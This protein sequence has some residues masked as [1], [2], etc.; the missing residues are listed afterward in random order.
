MLRLTLLTA[1]GAI[2]LAAQTPVGGPS[3]GFIFD[4]KGHAIRQIRGIPGA[5]VL[6]DPLAAASA[7]ALSMK[8][9][10]AIINDDGWKTLDLATG[11]TSALPD[12]LSAS[13]RVSASESGTAAAFYD[14]DAATLTVVTGVG[15]AEL[16]AHAVALPGAITALATAD[17]GALLLAV[18]VD[19]SSEALYWVGADGSARQLA[20]LQSTASLLLTSRGATA[21]VS[22]R[23]ANKIWKIQDPG[24]NAAV[25]LVASDAD[26]VSTPVG[27]ALS[28]DGKRLWIANSGAHNLLAVDLATRTASAL[29]SPSDLSTL[30]P[31]PDGQTFLLNE[32]GTGPLW[33]L[34]AAPA[35]DARIVF[36]PALP[37]AS[38][39]DTG[40]DAQ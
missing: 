22:D 21:I 40:E 11:N 9:N 27:A 26:G 15:T 28:A 13:A 12:G 35:A 20:T 14:A 8:Q 25:T 32:L 19:D 38:A 33:L 5:S 1:A 6:G 39:S 4:A 29:D 3:L 24:S 18:T 10:I 7:A 37:S 30:A 34:D 17:D 23:A 31:L 2:L 16:A 36:V